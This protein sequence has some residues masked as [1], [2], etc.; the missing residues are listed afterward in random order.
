M[1]S[2][3]PYILKTGACSG[4]ASLVLSRLEDGEERV[5]A[6]YCK[7]PTDSQRNY[8]LKRKEHLAVV[9]AVNT[10]KPYNYRQEDGPCFLDLAI[11]AD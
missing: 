1:D 5:V 9:L 8:H 7:T 10:F 4:A 11:P 2:A 3:I 6:S